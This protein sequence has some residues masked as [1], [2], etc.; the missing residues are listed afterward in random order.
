MWHNQPNDRT[1]PNINVVVLRDHLI[2]FQSRKSG[3]AGTRERELRTTPGS[4][5]RRATAPSSRFDSR[6]TARRLLMTNAGDIDR[7]HIWKVATRVPG[8]TDH[9][10]YRHRHVS[11]AARPGKQI[12]VLVRPHA[13]DG[14]ND[15]ADRWKRHEAACLSGVDEGLLAT[16]QVTPE[17]ILLGAEDGVRFTISCS[18][19]RISSRARSAPRSSSSTV[20]RSGRCSSATTTWTSI[21]RR[22]R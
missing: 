14:G 8:D 22:T 5:S 18:C 13:P 15:R 11:G 21:T 10:G 16:T 12:A 2:F 4:S 19:R 1:F 7:R 17:A 3:F 9:V 6:R 20:V